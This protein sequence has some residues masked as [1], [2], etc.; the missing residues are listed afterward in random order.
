MLTLSKAGKSTAGGK[1]SKT[2]LDTPLTFGYHIRMKDQKPIVD[3]HIT[4]NI[5]QTICLV[6]VGVAVIFT[7][8]DLF[9][10]VLG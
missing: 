9:T 10:V 5:I 7:M 2:R 1:K 6:L 3:L 4:L 8:R